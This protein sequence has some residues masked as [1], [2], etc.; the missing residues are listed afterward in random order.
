MLVSKHEAAGTSAPFAAQQMAG[1]P[2]RP[3]LPLV[4]SRFSPDNMSFTGLFK[5]EVEETTAAETAG[6]E[7]DTSAFF[8]QLYAR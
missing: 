7:S 4:P 6:T 1:Q 8:T 2:A 5:N 3:E